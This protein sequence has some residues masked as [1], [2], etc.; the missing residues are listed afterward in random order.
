MRLV[1]GFGWLLLS[2]ALAGP[3]AAGTSVLFVG[4]SFTYG[5]RP[6]SPA[7]SVSGYRPGSVTDLNGLGIGG[8]PAIFKSFTTQ[9]GLDYDVSLETVGGT[10]LEDHYNTKLP[11]ID[12]S[13]DVVVLQS[14]S[15]L[16][17]LRPGDPTSLIAYTGLLAD[18][19]HARN[20]D[21]DIYL[22]ATWSRADL[23]YRNPSPWLGK[24]IDAMARDIQAGY[25]LA[26]AAS[27]HVTDVIEVGGAWNDAMVSGLADS[28]PYDGI[29]AGQINL[30][31][32][33]R[34]H[35]GFYGSYLSALMQFG[36]ITGTD[37]RLLGGNEM[38]AAYFGFSADQT[39]A[40]QNIAYARLNRAAVVP[41][42]ASW[43]MLIIGFG[44]VGGGL[45]HRRARETEEVASI[46]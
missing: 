9:M 36:A 40:L 42:P 19:F 11:L 41:E 34:Y 43:A 28:N 31:A 16:D 32:R 25:E 26:A 24:P 29:G 18:V 21:V 23:T 46:S 14:Q 39:V 22:T 8:I 1:R 7:P 5:D 27:P 37:P 15:V 33:D 13:W 3:V 4:N 20:A 44:L 45:R 10:A 30:W 6:G 2:F 38:A 12:R 17:P 35:A